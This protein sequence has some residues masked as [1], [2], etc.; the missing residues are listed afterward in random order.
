MTS[1]NVRYVLAIGV[2][3]TEIESGFIV[4]PDSEFQEHG[5]TRVL[6][7]DVDCSEDIIGKWMY[8][9]TEKNNLSTTFHPVRTIY[10]KNPTRIV[11]GDVQVRASLQLKCVKGSR[12]FFTHPFFGSVAGNLS[13]GVSVD[14]LKTEPELWIQPYLCNGIGWKIADERYQDY[15]IPSQQN[16]NITGCLEPYERYWTEGVVTKKFDKVGDTIYYVCSPSSPEGLICLHQKYCPIDVEMVGL[17]VSVC[18]DWRHEVKRKVKLIPN[19][20]KTRVTDVE[21]ELQI[22]FQYKETECGKPRMEFQDENHGSIMIWQSMLPNYKEN[23]WYIG[24]IRHAPCFKMEEL[25]IMS[26]CHQIEGPFA[27]KLIQDEQATPAAAAAAAAEE[28]D[29]EEIAKMKRI[30]AMMIPKVNALL[31]HEEVV[32]AMQLA[33]LEEY[34]ELVE[35]AAKHGSVDPRKK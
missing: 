12:V 32:V 20:R 27:S 19:K 1:E 15:F 34:E 33:N 4:F 25:W 3:H 5:V 9:K 22:C 16:H 35:I 29:L 10:D 2:S 18:V 14:R 6:I 28:K 30:L 11:D 17:H 7:S 24:W 8:L 13:R 26:S 21:A 31:K 23:G